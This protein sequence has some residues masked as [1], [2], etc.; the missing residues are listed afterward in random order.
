MRCSLPTLW[1][2]CLLLTFSLPAEESIESQPCCCARTTQQQPIH[3]RSTSTA[4]SCKSQIPLCSSYCGRNDL[5]SMVE[6]QVAVDEVVPKVHY[7]PEKSGTYFTAELLSFLNNFSL[8]EQ[9]PHQHC[10]Q[11]TVAKK[12]LMFCHLFC[13]RLWPDLKMAAAAADYAK[14]YCKTYCGRAVYC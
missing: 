1:P 12:H 6:I 7:F 10:T 11:A 4:L 5:S 3:W 8:V 14:P 13:I 9:P 2:T